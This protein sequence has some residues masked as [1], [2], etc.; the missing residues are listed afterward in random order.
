MTTTVTG[1]FD[2]Y[3]AASAAVSDL[4]ASGIAQRDISI[5]ANNSAGRYSDGRLNDNDAADDAAKGAGIGAA[6][7]AGGGLLAGLG[8]LAIL[9]LGP[10]LLPAGW[11][12]RQQERSPAPRLEVRLAASWEG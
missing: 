5:V 6:V 9:V 1:L 12:R 2:T 3:E 11:H 8:L 10:S 7:G 4:E